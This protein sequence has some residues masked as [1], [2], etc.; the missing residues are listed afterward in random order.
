VVSV[1]APGSQPGRNRLVAGSSA[2]GVLTG[3]DALRSGATGVV[4]ALALALYFLIVRSGRVLV[5]TVVLTALALAVFTP[6]VTAEIALTERGLHEDVIVTAVQAG[7][8]PQGRITLHCSFARADGVPV[9]GA[10]RRGCRSGIAVGDRITVLFDPKGVLAPRAKGQFRLG[11][12]I[13]TGALAL[14]LPVLRFL[15]VVRS[16]CLRP[17]PVTPTPGFVAADRSQATGPAH[18]GCP[19]NTATV[20]RLPRH[21][22]PLPGLPGRHIAPPLPWAGKN[23]ACGSEGNGRSCPDY[24]ARFTQSQPWP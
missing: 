23:E 24:P 16:Y 18:R 13:A 9:P 6:R 11:R 19:D 7:R 22:S 20:P 14:T 1:V 5:G 10:I 3:P 8:S 12:L 21:T 2:S 4:C 15:A 17:S